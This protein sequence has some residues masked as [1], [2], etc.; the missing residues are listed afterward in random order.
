MK[1]LSDKNAI[2][3]VKQAVG[4]MAIEGVVLSQ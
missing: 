1:N 3:K 2:F 4:S